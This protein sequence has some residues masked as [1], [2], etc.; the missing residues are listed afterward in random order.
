[1]YETHLYV[2]PPVSF[3]S[4]HANYR[5]HVAVYS[6]KTSFDFSAVWPQD[7]TLC[8]AISSQYAAVSQSLRSGAG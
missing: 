5:P 2:S 8:I 4:L 3:E 7:Q 1:M 6:G